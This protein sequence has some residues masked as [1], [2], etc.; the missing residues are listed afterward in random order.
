MTPCLH[1]ISLLERFLQAAEVKPFRWLD[2][3]CEQ[4]KDEDAGLKS[5]LLILG[6]GGVEGCC[7]LQPARCKDTIQSWHDRQTIKLYASFCNVLI[8]QICNIHNVYVVTCDLLLKDSL[9]DVIYLDQ[10]IKDGEITT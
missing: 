7:T 2:L 1:F 6:G 9:E 10:G 4:E 8:L 3:T 5:I